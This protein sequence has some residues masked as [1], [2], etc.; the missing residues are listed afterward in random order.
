MSTLTAKPWAAGKLKGDNGWFAT[1]RLRPDAQFKED[2]RMISQEDIQELLA[3]DAG[4]AKVTSLYLNVDTSQQSSELIKKQARALMK[5]AGVSDKEADAIEQYLDFTYDWTKPG[6]AVFAAGDLDFFRAF[7]S[8]ISFR[9]RVRLGRRPYVKPLN[10]LLDHYAYY[11]VIVVDRIGAKFFEYHLGELQDASGTMGDDVRKQKL[12]GGS[13]RGGGTSSATG[14]RG[15]QG[16]RHEEEVVNRNMRDAAA[17]AS[18]FFA[19]KP[20]R[21]LFLAGTTENLALYRDY[22]PKQ[23]QSC[24]A[25]T[26]PADM[27]AGEHEIRER[28][29][30]MLQEANAERERKMVETM[31]T[32]AAKGGNAVVG[33]DATLKAL[34]DGRVQ[35]LVV[36]DG[37]RVRGYRDDNTGY[38]SAYEGE[39]PFGTAVAATDDVVEAAV[40]RA[41]ELGGHV[42]IISDD[43]AL[44]GVGRIGALLRY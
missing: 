32:T 35:T 41:M 2:H 15:G 31:I 3:L 33:L 38:L 40:S 6:L 17:A 23:L 29:L 1:S 7:P 9:N 4:D 39:S 18:D 24:I 5:E 11:G 34:N 36:S 12:G 16:G 13:S 20:I 28:S 19:R 37:Y 14:R 27:T 22:L 26:F 42:E 30:A 43:Q 25:G 8:A 44:E 10:H 21:R